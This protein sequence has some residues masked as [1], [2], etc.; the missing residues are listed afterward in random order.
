MDTSGRGME[1][2]SEDTMHIIYCKHSDIAE[3]KGDLSF[4]ICSAVNKLIPN[5]VLGA[6]KR[7]SVWV[8]GLQSSESKLSLLQS[9]HVI[10]D[11]VKVALTEFN[12]YTTDAK[13]DTER[14]L[15]KDFPLWEGDGAIHDFLKANT[16][17]TTNGVVHKSKARNMNTHGPSTF[18]NG[19]RYFFAKAN[20]HP[21][22][23]EKVKIGKHI[24]RV[25]YRSQTTS[26]RR[27]K[28]CR[29]D[30]HQIGDTNICPAYMKPRTELLAF[31]NGPL[32][33]FDRC[34]VTMD[35]MTFITSEHCYQWNAAK[36]ALNDTVAEAIFKAKSPLEAKKLAAQIKGQNPSW[37]TKK[38]GVMDQVIR[39][40]ANSSPTF[41]KFLIDTGDKILCEGREDHYW[42]T[43]L[44]YNL[45]ISTKSDF[46]PG[47]NNLGKILMTL[48]LELQQQ[49][50][51][52]VDSNQNQDG[53]M[54][55]LP[56]STDVQTVDDALPG[57]SHDM[58]GVAQEEKSSTAEPQSPARDGRVKLKATS[59]IRSSSTSSTTRLKKS[60]GAPLYQDFLRKHQQVKRQ[61][62]QSPETEPG[63]HDDNASVTSFGSFACAGVQQRIDRD[64]DPDDG[65]NTC[66]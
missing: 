17:I 22:I 8:I 41:R 37:H 42:G 23:P 13:S 15:I 19:D 36:D 18:L 14:V 16:H 60:P 53:P 56:G 25:S 66:R 29:L 6:Q 34:D 28:R 24:C 54:D 27:C 62:I 58:S 11:N 47:E 33:N 31:V 32:S 52:T 21:A 12:P 61:R 2:E 1:N 65:D 50:A 57:T 35:S 26:M 64:F 49:E 48:R 39:A 20:F 9:G 45:T 40:K 5:Q 43:G 3:V 63:N 44:N 4:L 7:K 10:V 59:K 55:Q 46:W 30:G 51:Q 38:Y